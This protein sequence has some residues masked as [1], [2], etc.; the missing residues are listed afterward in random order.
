MG[1]LPLRGG[2]GT[3]EQGSGEMK[4]AVDVITACDGE[5]VCIQDFCAEHHQSVCLRLKELKSKEVDK[6]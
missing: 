3:E 4:C 5:A 1:L 2:Q 6:G